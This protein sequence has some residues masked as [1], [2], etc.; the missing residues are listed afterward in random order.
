MPPSPRTFE[1]TVIR[2]YPH[3]IA[4]VYRAWTSVEHIEQWFRPFDDVTLTVEQFD[5]REGGDYFFRY[6]WPESQYLFSGARPSLGAAGSSSSNVHDFPDTP[7]PSRPAAPKDGR[8]PLNT[9]EGHFP[10]RGKFLTIRP[11]HSLIFS[12]EPQ[13]PD[14]D[15]GKET[16]VSVFF[17]ALDAGHTEIE[18]RH[19]L[20]PDESMRQRHDE[21]WNA[22]L[23]RLSR[24]L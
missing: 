8:A 19:T 9:Y 5:L 3:P 1:A 17:R 16:M 21:G 18:V 12:W 2:R 4:R 23:D 20:F 24:H 6:T 22:T 15:A 7:S 13:E 11:E 10:V 14:P